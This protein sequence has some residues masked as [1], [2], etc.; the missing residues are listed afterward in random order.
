MLYVCLH[1]DILEGH[2]HVPQ[3]VETSALYLN[4]IFTTN[5]SSQP[6]LRFYLSY[7]QHVL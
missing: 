1:L 7:M 3:D 4:Q 2:Y 6:G 5:F